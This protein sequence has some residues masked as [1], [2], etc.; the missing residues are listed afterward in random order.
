MIAAA[1][2]SECLGRLREQWIHPHFAGYLC[3]KRTATRDLRD[4]GLNPN[5]KRDF[6]ELFLRV[7]GADP[8]KPYIRPFLDEAPSAANLWFNENVAGSYAP[9]SFRR[10]LL[11]VITIAGAGKGARFSFRH[12]HWGLART[13]L[14]RGK[15]IPVLDLVAVLYRDYGLQSLDGTMADWVSVFRTEFGYTLGSDNVPRDEFD[16]LYHDDS[17]TAGAEWLER[18]R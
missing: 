13:H 6:F 1:K 12:K 17:A 8:S 2:V 11:K 10:T 4:T 9:S 14:L 5:F 3:L 15:T 18:V 16:A 7:P